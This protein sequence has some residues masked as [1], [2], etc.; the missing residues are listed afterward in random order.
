MG[1]PQALMILACNNNKYNYNKKNQMHLFFFI[2]NIF[3]INQRICRKSK[4]NY[5]RQRGKTIRSAN[6]NRTNLSLK[7][8]LYSM[9][10]TTQF[11]YFFYAEITQFSSFMILGRSAALCILS[12][13]LGVTEID[14]PLRDF[15]SQSVE[16]SHGAYR[17]YYWF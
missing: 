5:T 1:D 13:P 3:F 4:K 16:P 17:I 11:I 12:A 10:A 15:S 7:L 2:R 8:H 6:Y 14:W 9:I